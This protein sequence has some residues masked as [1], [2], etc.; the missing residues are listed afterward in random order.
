MDTEIDKTQLRECKDNRQHKK[1]ETLVQDWDWWKT[2]IS[3]HFSY[4]GMQF[5]H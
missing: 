1:Q 4:Y 5:G 3:W 2:D